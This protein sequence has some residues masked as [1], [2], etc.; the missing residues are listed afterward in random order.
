MTS[1]T[2]KDLI[3]A[4]RENP[5][6]TDMTF[7]YTCLRDEEITFPDGPTHR[8][9]TGAILQDNGDILFRIY[10]P[11]ATDVRVEVT[12]DPETPDIHLKKDS[13]GFF[14]GILLYQ[15][16]LA[17]PKTINYYVDGALM[18][19]PQTPIFYWNFRP[20][21]YIEVPD[22]EQLFLLSRRIPRGTIHRE[23]YWSDV[24]GEFES[25]LVYTPAGYST[26][27]SY[28]V[29]YLQHGHTED[30]TCW[31]YNGKA[32][33]ILDA[34]IEEGSAVPMIVVMNNGMLRKPGETDQDYAGFMEML[35]SDCLPF[36]EEHYSVRTDKWSRAIAGL[37]M[38]SAQASLIGQSRPDLFG[39]V[40]LFSG[41]L[42]LSRSDVP[43]DEMPY[44]QMLF[45]DQERFIREFRVF[46]RSIG[47]LDE[48]KGR[49]DR[50]S[51]F[52]QKHGSDH[53]PN[54]KSVIYPGRFHDWG[55]WRI[56]LR[57]FARMLFQ[58]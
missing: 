30:E 4:Y 47:D 22:Q 16:R 5:V 38:G 36:I 28:P 18:L 25:C 57:D 19:H 49:F 43:V 17:G 27:Q 48:L 37:S 12:I 13:Q 45:K 21:N 31:I 23:F 52:L 7:G 42:S 54:L 11:E 46:Y 15:E 39:Y 24:M 20:A 56:A 53:L 32:G 10:A 2:I 8:E 44:L 1:E 33:Y 9:K 29:L 55:T 14:T 3:Q 35:L 40:G 41:F 6:F 26:K 50:D 51:E 58:D 34:L